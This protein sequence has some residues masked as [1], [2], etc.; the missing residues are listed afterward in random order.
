MKNNQNY[1]LSWY[2]IITVSAL[3]SILLFGILTLKRIAHRN[4]KTDEYIEKLDQIRRY[5][6]S[7]DD[8]I[9]PYLIYNPYE[10]IPV[11][12]KDVKEII[13]LGVGGLDTTV[14]IMNSLIVGLLVSLF[15][16]SIIGFG[17]LHI[18]VGSAV[19]SSLIVWIIQFI[20][21]KSRYQHN[22]KAKPDT[23]FEASLIISSK[24]PDKVIQGIS[25]LDFITYYQ[26]KHLEPQTF[27]DF[28]YDTP[29]CTLDD[30]KYTLRI[31]ECDAE[32][33]I[34]LKGPS[35]RVLWFS[36]KKEIEANWDI[37]DKKLDRVIKELKRIG[38]IIPSEK[39]SF[40]NSSIHN[41]N[42]NE[43]IKESGLINIQNRITERIRREVIFKSQTIAELD[44]DTVCYDLN[45]FSFQ[46]VSNSTPDNKIAYYYNIEVEAKGEF[47]DPVV[48]NSC[49]ED[50]I[51][52]EPTSIKVTKNSKFAIGKGI[53]ILNRMGKLD[54]LLLTSSANDKKILS[55]DADQEIAYILRK[56]YEISDILRK[57]R[58]VL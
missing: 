20:Y 11:R 28:Y 52:L 33:K 46:S 47:I 22:K 54:K 24:E 49:V 19:A 15:I 9:V 10:P 2:E 27:H 41:S 8:K 26:L 7:S 4:K 16:I 44:I 55:L 18:S 51:R 42:P 36:I 12:R 43:I 31:R 57:N 56:E 32:Y 5:F 53:K 37:N 17:N 50:L 1:L 29:K 23:E 39:I 35:K 58:V 3:L 38:V 34:T 40:K 45:Q 13:T 21:L 30:K 6:T 25:K 48:L 14:G